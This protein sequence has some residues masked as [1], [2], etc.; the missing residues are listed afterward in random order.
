MVAARRPIARRR[1]PL[2]RGV[3]REH[4]DALDAQRAAV[5]DVVVVAFHRDQLA[6][7]NRGDHAAAARAEVARG[8]ELVDLGELQLL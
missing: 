3:R 8:G 7:A 2:R 5:H 4:G 6:V 1:Q